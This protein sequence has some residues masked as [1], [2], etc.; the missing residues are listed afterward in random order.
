MQDATC[1]ADAVRP[2][3]GTGQEHR[4]RRADHRL[5][6]GV[7]GTASPGRADR[8]PRGGFGE[9]RDHVEEPGEPTT[10][11]FNVLIRSTENLG[12]ALPH[13]P[14]PTPAK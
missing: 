9:G 1:L 4:E 10:D 2:C 3:D 14:N 8:E 12:G 13:R 7:L 6:A 5:Q 11:R